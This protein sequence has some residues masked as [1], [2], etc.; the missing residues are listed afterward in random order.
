[1]FFQNELE[2]KSKVIS[3]LTKNIEEMQIE[4]L[5]L[6][7]KNDSKSTEIQDLNSELK[8]KIHAIERSESL[9]KEHLKDQAEI[10]KLKSDVESW[11][12]K[13]IDLQ[14]AMHNL[15]K[16]LKATKN[17][18]IKPLST[19]KKNALVTEVLKPF[20][21]E[22]QISAILRGSWKK[23]HNW[24]HDDYIHALTIRLLSR[25]TYDYLRQKK[26]LPLPGHSNL[27]RYFQEFKINEGTLD[28]VINL[29]KV[30]AAV[31]KPVERV[32]S[33]A[34]D[35]VHVRS[36]ISWNPSNDQVVGP[37]K[38]ANTMM[39]R[40]IFTKM[41]IPIWYRFDK[42]LE[43]SEL[44]EI[45]KK[46]EEAGFHVKSIVCDMGPKNQGL[47]KALGIKIDYKNPEKSITWFEN[48]V[49]KGSKIFFF[50]DVPHLL[51]LA[52]NNIQRYGVQLL[53]GAQ[54]SEDDV[55][56]LET[57][58]AQSDIETS[59]KLKNSRIY[60]VKDLDKQKV[61]W[62]AQ[63]LSSSMADAIRKIHQENPAMMEF[64]DLIQMIDNA[65]DTL[66]S[67]EVRG[68]SVKE[69]NSAYG[70]FLEKQEEALETLRETVLKI[71][72]LNGYNK[73]YIEKGKDKINRQP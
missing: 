70:K 22:T 16:Q 41:K 46:I 19:E 5:D 25:K 62:A 55:S 15:K 59:S 63:Y 73:K 58:I 31:L 34:F 38:N 39:L 64:A 71:R 53:S 48:P 57:D 1:M 35:E 49:R 40:L 8:K 37:H 69:L 36:D 20:F 12:K 61:I 29:L 13:N 4:V 18:K 42:A 11:R 44:F 51:K 10:K 33:L 60:D 6:T 7:K 56:D 72:I 21:S 65:F 24:S 27:K 2:S 45:I 14:K 28:S 3:D 66:N 67:R 26:C 54:I 17:R 68:R 9:M 30:Q 47:A 43:K 52:R 50:Y 32:V 23:I